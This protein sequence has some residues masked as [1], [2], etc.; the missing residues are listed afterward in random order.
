[1]IIQNNILSDLILQTDV[2]K[3]KELKEILEGPYSSL[4]K[5]S[6][7]SF[8]GT[9][10]CWLQMPL[11]CQNME[12]RVWHCF[13]NVFCGHVECFKLF[14]SLEMTIFLAS[15]K[16]HCFLGTKANFSEVWSKVELANLYYNIRL[17]RM[18]MICHI[19]FVF[20]FATL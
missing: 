16:A 19:F 1:M 5:F 17:Y 14:M 2:Q 3:I 11:N 20:C 12:G 8:K 10:D 7:A 9:R 18:H 15:H 13:K 4:N 6:L